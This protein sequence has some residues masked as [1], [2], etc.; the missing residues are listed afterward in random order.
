VACVG[1]V[2][3]GCRRLILAG[4]PVF[5]VTV[6]FLH[7]SIPSCVPAADAPGRHTGGPR[8]DVGER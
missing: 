2:L 5:V 6:L 1:R 4:G 7:S 3:P 8:L